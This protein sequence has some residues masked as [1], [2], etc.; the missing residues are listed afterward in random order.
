[1]KVKIYALFAA[2]LLSVFACD[3]KQPA[4]T[5]QSDVSEN[6]EIETD[7]IHEEEQEPRK[8]SINLFTLMPK[9][10]T[11]IA[12][13]SLSDIYNLGE[14]NDSVAMP[15][16]AKMDKKAAEYFVLEN[17]YRKKFLSQIHI[18]ESDS[19][20]VYDYAKN[21]LAS[22][23]VKSLKTTA[24]INGYASTE[25]FPYS[26]SDYMIGFEIN[27]KYLNGFSEYYRDALVYVGKENPFAKE[28]LTPIAWKK[29]TAKEYP[30]KP[31]K[32]E[33]Q[34]LLKKTVPGNTYAFK[35]NNYQYF[36]QDY[37]DNRKNLYARRLL[38]LDSNT[39]DII[40]EK[41]YSQ[42]EGTSPSPLNYEEG[43]D[44][45]NQWTGKLFKDKPP[46]VF[47]FLYESFGCPGISIIDKSNE[48]IYLQ[49]DNRH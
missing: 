29:I 28:R 26:P 5:T 36:L 18:S 45:V 1:M 41:L 11:D 25:D 16:I 3:K 44:I 34:K 43:E 38:V 24:M 17:K 10:S 42:S 13:V 2:I 47:G 4:K 40:I 32:K 21:K 27:K 9:D 33:D 7:S 48:E 49:C 14:T 8:E 20:F 6:T 15:V 35:T 22:F 19:L 31:I 12:F 46:V 39:K 30:S 37:V 23:S